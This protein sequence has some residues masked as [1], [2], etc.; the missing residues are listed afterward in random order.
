M[1]NPV[2]FFE[3]TGPDGAVLQSFYSEVFGWAVESRPFPSY[4]YMSTDQ[5]G[6][7]A[8]GI[9]EEPQAPPERVLYIRVPDLQAALDRVVA[10]GGSVLIPPT[11]VPGIVPFALFK[12]PA[13]NAT[14]LV[15]G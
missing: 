5:A 9:R 4:A 1:G 15:K 8:G 2:V 7:Q 13:G 3:I 14:G 12:D 11:E 6:V 10:Q